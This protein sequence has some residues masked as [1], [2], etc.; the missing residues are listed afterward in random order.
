M[1][2]TPRYIEA[3]ITCRCNAACRYCYYADNA[4][5]QYCDLPTSR[6]LDFF[7]ELGAN[8]VL[9]VCFSGGEPLL[10]EDLPQLVDGVVRNRMR[11]S[12]LTN[13]SLLTRQLARMLRD[14]RR[15][16]S[17][18]VS[19]DGATAPVHEALRGEGTFEPAVQ[20]VKLLMEEGV[21]TTVRCTVHS[22]NVRELPAVARLLLDDIGIPFFSTNAVSSLGTQA[23]YADDLF[24]TPAERLEAM[25]ILDGL[26]R[27]YPGRIRAAAGPLAEWR[28]F[29]EMEQARREGKTMGKGRLMGCGC[30]F[31]RLSVMS[32]GAYVP[33][34]MLPQMVL[35]YMGRDSLADVWQNA[36]E[37]KALRDRIHIPLDCFEECSNCDYME[38]CGGNCAGTALSV[39]GDA[40]RPSPDG[41]LRNFKHELAEVGLSLWEP[42]DP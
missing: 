16:D 4:G 30:I 27:Q 39:L 13:G 20:A 3:A 34:V 35:G 36:P 15:C 19:L 28:M 7:D 9:N 23:K 14:T 26:E 29:R 25:R 17:V 22:R 31:E 6:W 40:N 32:D 24:L 1:I 11:F 10:R 33:C 21:V 38:L 12:L 8:N 41:C 5:V 42:N 2:P 18:Q 37:L